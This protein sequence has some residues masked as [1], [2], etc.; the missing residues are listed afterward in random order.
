MAPVVGMPAE[1]KDGERRIALDAAA[2][3]GLTR[4]GATVLVERGAGAG[5]GFDDDAYALAG[6]TVVPTAADAWA[7]DVV[8]KVKEPQPSE[9]GFLRPDLTLFAFL[10][11]AASPALAEALV[12][13]GTTALAFETVTDRSGL[14]LLAP[15]S[16][17]A[18]RAAA[19]VGAFWLSRG[20]G[21]LAGGA[22]GVLPARTAV[23][24]MGVAGTMAAR[25]LRG[26]DAEVLGIDV[27]LSRLRE[28]HEAGTVTATLA[29]A[30]ELV[31]DAVAGCDLVVGAALVPGARAPVVLTADQVAAMRP[32]S[33]VVDLA[34]DQGGCIETSRPTSHSDPVYEEHG[35]LHYCVTNV[36]GQYPRTATMALS[37]ALAPRVAAL[38][39]DPGHESLA[40]GLNTAGGRV[41]HPVVAAAL[42]A[43]GTRRADVAEVAR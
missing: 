25:G 1:V 14:P 27:D 15:M 17:I 13:T 40:G 8:V 41:T 21:V 2:V 4:R 19:I 16:E 22:A 24:G 9:H 28:V 32:G 6:A 33:V 11:L 7:A 42:D 43:A 39:A 36:P 10:H 35:V 18:G 23:I 29:S 31:G 38:L 5:A 30:P 12:A 37:A 26:L 34:I 20:S 3:A